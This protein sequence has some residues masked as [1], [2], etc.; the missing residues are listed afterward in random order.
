MQHSLSLKKLTLFFKQTILKYFSEKDK[1]IANLNLFL[2]GNLDE[3]LRVSLLN[4]QVPGRPPLTDARW[5]D[6]TERMRIKR[7][8]DVKRKCY[9]ARKELAILSRAYSFREQEISEK[10]EEKPEVGK[11]VPAVEVKDA[12]TQ[13]DK[14]EDEDDDDVVKMVV[15]FEMMSAQ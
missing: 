4:S 2:F 14:V 10:P 9:K 13:T 11:K 6:S 5:R 15:F 12:A 1:F 3:L 7:F 8:G